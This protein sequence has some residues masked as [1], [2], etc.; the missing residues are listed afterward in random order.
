MNTEHFTRILRITLN[1][2]SVLVHPVLQASG[3]DAA[4]TWYLI[5][6]TLC[7]SIFTLSLK[8]GLLLRHFTAHSVVCEHKNPSLSAHCL[9][10][11]WL[12]HHPLDARRIAVRR[13]HCQ[14]LFSCCVREETPSL[15]VRCLAVGRPHCHLLFSHCVSVR[16]L[17]LGRLP[18]HLWT[19]S[20]I[21]LSCFS[22]VRL[23]R[24]YTP[25]SHGN[26]LVVCPFNSKA[27]AQRKLWRQGVRRLHNARRCGFPLQ[28]YHQIP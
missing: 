5:H 6:T 16:K 17:P 2:K 7:S 20:Y 13:L 3:P 15:S 8:T 1:N 26:V 10:V 22:I 14:P 21:A 24:S 23:C 11:R 27:L 18:V 28:Y 4:R 25:F 9:T 12:P 19:L